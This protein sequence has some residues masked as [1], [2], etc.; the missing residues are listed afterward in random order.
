VPTSIRYYAG[1]R[2]RQNRR[3]NVAGD[4]LLLVMLRLGVF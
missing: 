1:Y 4:V 2:K 3:L